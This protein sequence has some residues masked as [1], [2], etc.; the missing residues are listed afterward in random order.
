MSSTVG[1][2]KSIPFL[3]QPPNLDGTL[4]GDV[5]FD[6][7][8]LSTIKDIGIDLYWMREAELKH[9]RVAMLAALGFIAQEK[10]LFMIT[11]SNH[12]QVSTFYEYAK[13]YPSSI[14]FF[15]VLIGIVELF[16]G[17]AITEGRKSG[18]REPGNF[19]FNPLQM[20]RKEA[21]FKDL[22]LKEIKNGRLAMIAALGMLVQSSLFAEE[23]L[24]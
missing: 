6:P 13:A 19:G 9:S 22:S 23:G 18:D 20:G 8:G 14:G 24:F 17:I 4:S 5:G 12:N 21:T 16:S 3:K 10:G 11:S 2:S 7:L 1:R 15:I